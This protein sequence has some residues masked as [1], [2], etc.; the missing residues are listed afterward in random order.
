MLQSLIER[1]QRGAATLEDMK[2]MAEEKAR[3]QDCIDELK[4]SLSALDKKRHEK[5]E[6]VKAVNSECENAKARA[7]Q[8]INELQNLA[9][10]M[11]RDRQELDSLEK[12]KLAVRKEIEGLSRKM[13]DT[14]S[15]SQASP[16]F[17]K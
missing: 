9:N 11:V 12:A 10:E 6:I 4:Q 7:K 8:T 5:D 2:S 1:T 3:L 15:L 13:S 16:L 17:D 14:S